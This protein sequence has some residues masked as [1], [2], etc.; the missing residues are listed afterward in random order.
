MLTLLV[1]VGVLVIA[2]LCDAVIAGLCVLSS[3]ASVLL[4]T[5]GL[6]TVLLI[7]SG[8]CNYIH[9]LQSHIIC[10]IWLVCSCIAF[11]LCV[12]KLFLA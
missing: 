10:D 2:G 7:T 4:T 5:Y 11:G 8:L 9:L 6:S 12:F 3:S 1:F